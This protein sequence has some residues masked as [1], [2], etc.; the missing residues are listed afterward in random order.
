MGLQAD[1]DLEKARERPGYRLDREVLKLL[2]F[3][4]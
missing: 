1:Y 4:G 2:A 3:G